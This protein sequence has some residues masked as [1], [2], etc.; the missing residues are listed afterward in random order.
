MAGLLVLIVMAWFAFEFLSVR[1]GRQS[2][3][4][5]AIIEV[6]AEPEIA[7]ALTEVATAQDEQLAKTPD[8]CY[9]LRVL[10]QEPNSVADRLTGPRPGSQPDVWVPD[11]TFWLRR[12]RAGGA[13]DLPEAGASLASSPVVLA[14]TE[15][16]ARRLGWPEHMLSWPDVLGATPTASALTV[17]M[18]DPARSPVGLSTLFGVRAMTSG[19]PEPG[20]AQ[21]AALRRLSPNVTARAAELFEK[22]PPADTAVAAFPASE[23]AVLHHNKDDLEQQRLVP[24][25]A[26]PGVPSLDYPYVVLP[27]TSGIKRTGAERFLESLLDPAAQR[28]LG[29]RGLRTPQ[30]EAGTDYP[31]AETDRPSTVPAVPLPDQDSTDDVQRVWTGVNLSARMLT[32]ID[33]SGS[34]A[35]QVPGT[36]RSRAQV[37]AEA[38]KQGLGLFKPTTDMGLWVFSDNLDGDRDYRELAPIAPLSTERQ[39]LVALADQVVTMVGGRTN[40]YDTVLAAYQTVLRGWDAARLNV[41]VVLTDG[42]DDDVSSITRQQLVDEL[43]RLQDPKKPTRLIFVGIGPDVDAAELDQIAAVTGGRAFTTPNP[44]GIRDVFAQALAELTC[45]PPECTKTR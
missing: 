29:M 39:H 21:V 28:I 5:P 1:L 32:V 15:P 14:V 42:R 23:Q 17:G 31:D 26:S 36:R 8:T 44:A 11:S 9:Q 27:T 41:V 35:A 45:I 33:V 40:L 18:P 19:G 34:M 12:A 24:V 25:Y 37:T 16:A 20:A 22:L 38:T 43:A 6:A 3:T 30:G 7:S 2:C 10:S 4:N 13:I